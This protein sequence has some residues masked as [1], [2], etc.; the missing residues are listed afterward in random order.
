MRVIKDTCSFCKKE[1]ISS[2]IHTQEIFGQEFESVEDLGH[3]PFCSK[4]CCNEFYSWEMAPRTLEES[5][6]QAMFLVESP[7]LLPF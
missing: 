1:Y 4:Q 6:Q 5:L 7:E 2:I 3:G